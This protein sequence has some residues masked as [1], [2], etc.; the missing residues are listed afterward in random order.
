MKRVP[1]SHSATDGDYHAQHIDT[2]PSSPV[3]SEQFDLI[4]PRRDCALLSSFLALL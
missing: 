3:E 2:V 1:I 4:G